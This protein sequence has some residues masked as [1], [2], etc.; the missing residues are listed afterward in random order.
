MHSITAIDLKDFTKDKALLVFWASW[1]GPCNDTK[2]L[3]L[4]EEESK[5]PVGRINCGENP[6]LATEYS[7]KCVPTYIFFKS[8]KMTKFLPGLKTATELHKESK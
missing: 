6:D 8:G 2:E 3:E 7:I 1:Y 4:F 5:I